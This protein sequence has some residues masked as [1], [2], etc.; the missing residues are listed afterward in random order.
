MNNFNNLYDAEIERLALLAEEMGEAIQIIGKILRHG[1]ESTHP[2]GEDT[3]HTLL[4]NELGHVR[5]AMIYM[6]E[7]G[8]LDKETIHKQADLKR[9]N[10]KKYFHHQ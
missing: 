9:E 7:K 2:N 8:D 4:E 5:F 1:Y 3:N 6:C 10:V